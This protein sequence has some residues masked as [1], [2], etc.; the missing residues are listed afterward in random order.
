M[1]ISKISEEYDIDFD[2]NYI[3]NLETL[4]K[5]Y[6]KNKNLNFISMANYLIELLVYNK[7][8]VK[9]PDIDKIYEN[10]NTSLKDINNFVLYNLGQNT[11]INSISKR[12]TDE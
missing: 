4:L 1:N 9:N 3:Q 7:L 11:I 10:K 12:F 2:K 8:R 5:L 6:K